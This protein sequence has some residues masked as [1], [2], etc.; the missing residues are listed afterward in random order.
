VNSAP[1]PPFPL[2]HALSTHMTWFYLYWQQKSQ[3]PALMDMVE[4]ATKRS[5]E[6]TN[7][8]RSI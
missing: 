2:L 3:A 5:Y 7:T 1:F 4:K 6:T 8:P